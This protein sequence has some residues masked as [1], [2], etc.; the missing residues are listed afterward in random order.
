MSIRPGRTVRFDRSISRAPAG[1]GVE[2]GGDALDA[3]VD[4]GDGRGARRGP[5]RIGDQPAGMDDDGFGGGGAG[6]EQQQEEGEE[7]CEHRRIPS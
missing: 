6:G 7:A 4:D 5:R 2:A 3:A 1:G